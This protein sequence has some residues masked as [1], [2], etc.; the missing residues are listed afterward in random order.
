MGLTR[1]FQ[2]S[3]IMWLPLQFLPKSA[4]NNVESEYHFPSQEMF[5]QKP[6]LTST[7]RD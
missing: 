5:L 1:V 3:S 4:S 7:K 2:D 6:F